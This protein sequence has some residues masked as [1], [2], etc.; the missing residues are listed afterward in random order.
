MDSLT[1]IETVEEPVKL[2]NI[3]VESREGDDET[4]EGDGNDVAR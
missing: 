3:M 4:K 2:E 1:D